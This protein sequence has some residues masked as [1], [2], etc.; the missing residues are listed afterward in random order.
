MTAVT[1]WSRSS[2]SWYA[3]NGRFNRGTTGF[4]RVSVSGRSRVPWPPARMTACVPTAAGDATVRRET[5][6]RVGSATRRRPRLGL[7][8]QHHRDAVADGVCL[9]AG[10][11]DDA[12]LLEDEV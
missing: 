4:G 2:A 1:P 3:R 10:R 9:L 7:V 5:P 8:D 12:R 6:R 11:A